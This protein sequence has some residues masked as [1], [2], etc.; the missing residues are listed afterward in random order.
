MTRLR[1]IARKKVTCQKKRIDLLHDKLRSRKENMF[2]RDG[3]I[4]EVLLQ[5][6]TYIETNLTESKEVITNL[7]LSPIFDKYGEKIST[8]EENQYIY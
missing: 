6:T 1:T 2:I 7:F 4:R 5:A 8:I 3:G